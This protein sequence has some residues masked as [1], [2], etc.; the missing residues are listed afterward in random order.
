LVVCVGHDGGN[1]HRLARAGERRVGVVSEYIAH[2]RGGDAG[3]GVGRLG[4]RGS[5]P[6]RW[7]MLLPRT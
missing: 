4:T 5:P 1:R 7:Q 6:Q 2:V 3:F